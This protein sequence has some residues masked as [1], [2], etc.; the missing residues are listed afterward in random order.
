[1]KF[2]SQSR[3]KMN[4]F[5]RTGGKIVHFVNLSQKKS[6][7]ARDKKSRNS[8]ML[9]EKHEI[10]TRQREKKHA[11]FGSKARKKNQGISQSVPRLIKPANF[12]NR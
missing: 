1:M 9:A 10:H 11:S 2:A 5:S 6:T 12:A 3:E 4:Y 7:I 8:S